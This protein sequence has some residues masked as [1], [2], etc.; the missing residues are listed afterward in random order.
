MPS[1]KA[2]VMFNVGSGDTDGQGNA[3]DNNTSND[4][5]YWGLLCTVTTPTT[6]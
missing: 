2:G 5:D 4:F 1:L 6:P 3:T